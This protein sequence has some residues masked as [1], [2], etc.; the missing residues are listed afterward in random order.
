MYTTHNHIQAGIL[1]Y[2]VASSPWH[3]SAT[4]TEESL[5]TETSYVKLKFI[6]Y[7]VNAQ[8]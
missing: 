2:N 6:L 1:Y 4:D 7:Y 3:S 5:K 8:Y